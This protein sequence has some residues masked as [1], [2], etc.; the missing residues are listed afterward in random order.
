MTCDQIL[1]PS[2]FRASTE[3]APIRL[4]SLYPSVQSIL[5]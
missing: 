5:S 3:G 4:K 2:G 1:M